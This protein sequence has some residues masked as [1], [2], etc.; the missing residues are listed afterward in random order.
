MDRTSNDETR[1]A[2]LADR[3]QGLSELRES[4][5][6]EELRA[7]AKERMEKTFE[8]IARDLMSGKELDPVQIA[9]QRGFFAGM[10]FLL[11]SPELSQKKLDA[12]LTRLDTAEGDED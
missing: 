5:A 11:D 7:V 12:A 9:R 2:R 6:W 3:A 10:K 1:V 8:R 4:R